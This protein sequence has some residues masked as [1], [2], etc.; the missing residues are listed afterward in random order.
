MRDT[1]K[2]Y[3]ILEDSYERMV[4]GVTLSPEV[5]AKVCKSFHHLNLFVEEYETLEDETLRDFLNGALK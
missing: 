3:I 4:R 2:V 5:A 1:M